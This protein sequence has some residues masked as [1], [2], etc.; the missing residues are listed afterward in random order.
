[1][2]YSY[3]TKRYFVLYLNPNLETGMA[4]RTPCA[5]VVEGHCDREAWDITPVYPDDWNSRTTYYFARHDIV[6]SVSGVCEGDPR[7]HLNEGDEALIWSASVDGEAVTYNGF[8]CRVF[9][10]EQAARDWMAQNGQPTSACHVCGQNVP[11]RLPKSI[12]DGWLDVDEV[13]K[14]GKNL[15][16]N[17]DHNGEPCTGSGAPVE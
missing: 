7:E 13:D 17:H 3:V 9:S 12:Y 15:L 14:E 5:F 11:V 1:M 4:N 10:T 2:L 16:T 6:Y 8:T